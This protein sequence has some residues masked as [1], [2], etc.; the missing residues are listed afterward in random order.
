MSPEEREILSKSISELAIK[1]IAK[2]DKNKDSN[3]VDQ[4]EVKD[5]MKD[6]LRETGMFSSSNKK[7][8][9]LFEE[10]DTDK[11]MRIS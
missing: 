1:I 7:I 8:D 3:E 11:N 5:F 9:Q 10:F 6:L 2:C 4:K